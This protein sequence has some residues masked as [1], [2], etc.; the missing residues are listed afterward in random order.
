MKSIIH[1]FD[2]TLTLYIRH[3]PRSW[4]PFF[5]FFTKAGDPI[6]VVAITVAIIVWSVVVLKN[7]KVAYAALLIPATLVAGFSLKL[8]FERA[9]PIS[10]FSQVL[11]LDTFSFP[12][13]HST[14]SMIAYGLL[15]YILL[16]T[17]PNNY[18]I[19]AVLL[20]MAIPILVGVSR[21][22]LGVHYPSDVLAGWLL[23]LIGLAVVMFVIKPFA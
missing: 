21:V 5:L 11:R 13:G 15:A 19:I 16:H 2:E 3:I 14:G 22:Y 17:L 20:V 4:D 1:R 18:A 23:G 9:R 7:I 6:T 8:L 10:E 12:S